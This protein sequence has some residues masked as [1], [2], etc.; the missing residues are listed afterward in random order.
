MASVEVSRGFAQKSRAA[1]LRF[2]L[3]LS[4]WERA[5][6][7]LEENGTP[8]PPPRPPPGKWGR[9]KTK[10]IGAALGPHPNPP[11]AGEGDKQEQKHGLGNLFK[12]V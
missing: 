2:S 12:L 4:H 1:I 10:L 6:R 3:S 11:P 8:P 5:G 9:E 7:G